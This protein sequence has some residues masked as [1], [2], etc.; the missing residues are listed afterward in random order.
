MRE[1]YKLIAIYFIKKYQSLNKSLIYF[2]WKNEVVYHILK[3]KKCN[4]HII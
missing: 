4:M 1:I 3:V 2:L